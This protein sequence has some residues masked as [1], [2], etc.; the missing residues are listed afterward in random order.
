M[1]FSGDST[2]DGTSSR[3]SLDEGRRRLSDVRLRSIM[4]DQTIPEHRPADRLTYLTRHTPAPSAA[5]ADST[6][7]S[8]SRGDSLEAGLDRSA[9]Q[10]QQQQQPQPQPPPYS[11]PFSA[12]AAAAE[13]L[14][15]G[16][17]W[18]QLQPDKPSHAEP[19][20]PCNPFGPPV[21]PFSCNDCADWDTMGGPTVF[22]GDG[23][24]SDTTNFVSQASRQPFARAGHSLFGTDDQVQNVLLILKTASAALSRLRQQ[25]RLAIANHS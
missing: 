2:L 5:A 3:T 13:R 12:F 9:L 18:Q 6:L 20:P 22:Q 8:P 21:N 23:F 11:S 10:Q 15:A 14:P 1:S 17:G 19:P 25:L 16:E 24:D 4:T 7:F